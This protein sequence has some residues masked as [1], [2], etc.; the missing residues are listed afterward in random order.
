MA[1][2]TINGCEFYY[3]IQGNGPETIL[4]AHGLFMTNYAFHKQVDYFKETHR[5]IVFDQ[6]GHGQ[7]QMTESGYD[8]DSQTDD[9]SHLIEFIGVG[10]VHFAGHSMG[11]FM[12]LRLAAR[13]PDVVKSLILINTSAEKELHKIRNNLLKL[14]TGL[15]GVKA[16]AKP[17]HH[18][19]FGKKF[20]N[21]PQMQEENK[22]W[23]NHLSNLPKTMLRPA[24]EVLNRQSMGAELDKIVCPVLI[25]GG[26]KD[27]VLSPK[28]SEFIHDKLPQSTLRL[29]EDVGHCAAIEEPDQV[30]QLIEIF[31]HSQKQK[32]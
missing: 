24:T 22:Y 7:S 9:I 10:K 2:I 16:V 15:F 31:L 19:N 14:I 23:L 27:N 17:F 28:N 6:R 26:K 8:L 20:L 18:L 12:G 13:R 32:T 11:G 4:F 5:T 30:N 3:D 25:I 29:L 1:K 21:D